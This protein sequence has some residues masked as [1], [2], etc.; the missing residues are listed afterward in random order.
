MFVRVLS[1]MTRPSGSGNVGAITG[2]S[3]ERSYHQCRSLVAVLVLV[4]LLGLPLQSP[5]GAAHEATRFPRYPACR[6]HDGLFTLRFPR[7]AAKGF[8]QG[9]SKTLGSTFLLELVAEPAA[10]LEVLEAVDGVKDLLVIHR[11]C[12]SVPGIIAGSGNTFPG[13]ELNPAA[14]SRYRTPTALHRQGALR[15][16]GQP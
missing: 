9:S 4:C 8:G 16:S 10:L 5:Y 1:A 14:M 3:I 7:L 11:A 2:I 6:A 15:R 13:H 12:L